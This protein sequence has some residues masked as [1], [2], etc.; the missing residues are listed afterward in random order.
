MCDPVSMDGDTMTML[1]RAYMLAT[2]F[3]CIGYT[4]RIQR[5]RFSCRTMKVYVHVGYWGVFP[6]TLAIQPVGYSVLC[7]ADRSYKK[8]IDAVTS[9]IHLTEQ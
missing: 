2:L 5:E 6:T 9:T 8:A 7:H 1:I 4:V 3:F